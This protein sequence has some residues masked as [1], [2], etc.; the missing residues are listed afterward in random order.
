MYADERPA[1]IQLRDG[2]PITLV[3]VDLSAGKGRKKEDRIKEAIRKTN[4]RDNS[5]NVD[6]GVGW[7]LL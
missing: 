7:K 1:N 3:V 2:K 4:I 5:I 6:F